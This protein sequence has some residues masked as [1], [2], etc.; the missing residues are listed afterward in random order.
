MQ[1][2]SIY[3]L[4]ESKWEEATSGFSL[5]DEVSDLISVEEI[6]TIVQNAIHFTNLTK[7][8][9]EQSDSSPAINYK[10]LPFMSSVCSLF[11]QH[12]PLT[13]M[14][15]VEKEHTMR[16]D[17]VLTAWG[18]ERINVPKDGNCCFYAVAVQLKMYEN[19]QAN[20][21]IEVKNNDVSTISTHLRE[22]TVNEWIEN[23]HEYEEFMM[24]IDV[25][26]EAE[27]FRQ[28][29]FYDSQL[30]DSM[31][32]AL[33][34]TLNL[35]II[36]FTSNICY[37]IVYVTPREAKSYLPIYIAYMQCGPGHYDSVVVRSNKKSPEPVPS[38]ENYCTCGKNDKNKESHHCVPIT[39]KY[40]TVV[41][42]PCLKNGKGCLKCKCKNCNN[43][44]GKFVQCTEEG[45]K[46]K[47]FK[48]ENQKNIP[49]SAIYAA[50]CGEELSLG[51]RTT[52][53]YFVLE[54]LF[55][56]CQNAGLESI[57]DMSTIYSSVVELA[58]SFEENLPISPKTDIEMEKFKAEH[59]HNINVFKEL[60]YGQLIHQIEELVQN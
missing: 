56:H 48:H 35:P 37:P 25:M 5:S 4:S 27:K 32:L 43:P 47:R 11:F 13:V 41:R 34:N 9:L 20:I 38:V 10:F 17:Q 16:L 28:P 50:Q 42:C 57:S 8:I 53:E 14:S 44:L 59:F 36:V 18:M 55:K 60:C 33:A 31:V 7:H 12:Q 26:R 39:S 15:T 45:P 23:R 21:G 2:I 51:K 58:S 40:T 19:K 6:I 46:R 49:K 29:G 24:D 30:G 52:L 1:P 22:R 3:M 54:G